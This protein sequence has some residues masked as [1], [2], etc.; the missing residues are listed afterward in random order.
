MTKQAVNLLETQAKDFL[1]QILTTAAQVDDDSLDVLLDLFELVSYKKN[2]EIIEEGKIADYFYYIHKGIIRVYFY[3]NDKLVIERFEKEGGL[4]GGN[5]THVTKKTGTHIY[6]SVEEVQLLR[7]KYADLDELCKKSHQIER[8][9][10]IMMEHFHSGYV[11]RLSTFKSLSSEERYH[12][13]IQQ[14]GDIANRVSLKDV[15]N[16][17]GMTPETLSRIRSKYDK[18]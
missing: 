13:F 15:A 2:H 6:E 5:F 9:Y 8:L 18:Y 10:R 12:E 14:Y 1:R 7:I 16:Y 3:K 4:F 11:E 17:L